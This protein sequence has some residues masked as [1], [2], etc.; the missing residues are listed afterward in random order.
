VRPDEGSGVVAGHDVARAPERV[1]HAIGI[2]GQKHGVDPD[3][4]GRENLVLQ[5]D[6]YGLPPREVRHRADELLARFGLSDA[7]KRLVRTYSGGMKRKLDVAMGLTNR[8]EVLFLD[9]G[10]RALPAVLAALEGA[11]VAITPVQLMIWLLLFGALFKRVVEIPGF[12]EGSYI[13][14]LTPG[15]VVMSALFS[16]GWQG[17]AGSIGSTAA[18][19]RLA[20][21]PARAD[22]GRHRSA[23]GLIATEHGC[24]TPSR[25]LAGSLVTVSDAAEE[26]RRMGARAYDQQGMEIAVGERAQL[27][28]RVKL[29]SWLSLGWMTAEGAIGV[30]AGIA[31]NSIALI[32][33]GL[34]S[35]I[36]GIASLV[37]IWRF[38]GRRLHS[39]DAEER[40]QKV[41]AV[42]FFLLAPYIAVEAVHR[43]VTADAARASWVGIGL[44]VVSI[45]LMPIFG[46]TKR[47]LG[48]RLASNATAGEGTQNLL[49]AYLSA[50]ILVGLGA[51]A[52]LGLWWADPL[53]ALVVA[54][55]AVQAGMQTWR[56]EAC[57]DC[58]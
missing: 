57:D 51:N 8:P 58:C 18:L 39:D 23:L 20:G 46:R 36:E 17:W 28:R 5:G 30:T 33:Y 38:T 24:P 54:A 49:C 7:A 42:T 32:G 55:V 40:A 22:R 29:V 27:I 4:T 31:A 2:V 44:A 48:N 37:V 3:A 34:D 25:L 47:S 16:A 45:T 11:G 9:E 19:P 41:V 10:A 35:A 12:H 56:G 53:V 14:F 13:E 6:L 50:A 43:L 15:I 26:V 21:L 1:R 52:L